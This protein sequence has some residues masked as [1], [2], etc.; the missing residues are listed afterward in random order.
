MTSSIHSTENKKI[1]LS[2][3]LESAKDLGSRY[4]RV[5]IKPAESSIARECTLEHLHLFI[6]L[7]NRK[8]DSNR[9]RLTQGELS[10]IKNLPNNLQGDLVNNFTKRSK[11]SKTCVIM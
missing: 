5:T 7:F 8:N 1:I 2:L 6:S 3:S 4:I 9:R 11:R 10:L